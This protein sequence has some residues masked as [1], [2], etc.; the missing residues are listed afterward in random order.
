MTSFHNDR[1]KLGYLESLFPDQSRNYA[2]KNYISLMGQ[3]VQATSVEELE[4]A[5]KA[6]Y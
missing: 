1:D 6:A 5:T 3:D 2:M 4:H